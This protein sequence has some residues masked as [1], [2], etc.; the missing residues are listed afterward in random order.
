MLLVMID[1]DN[2]GVERRKRLLDEMLRT[3]GEPLRGPVEPILVLVPTWSIE[4]WLAGRMDGLTESASMK[5]QVRAP[6]AADFE[7]AVRRVTT[8]AAN[9]PL[10]SVRDASSELRRIGR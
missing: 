2:E 7:Q 6:T 4:T 8:L 1:G 10:P 5:L 9:E 3:H